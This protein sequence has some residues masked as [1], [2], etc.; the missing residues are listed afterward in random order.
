M[1]CK[2]DCVGSPCIGLMVD[3]LNVCNA[4]NYAKI[5]VPI[6]VGTRTPH[7]CCNWTT[8]WLSLPVFTVWGVSVTKFLCNIYDFGSGMGHAGLAFNVQHH[9]H[10]MIW[11]Q[12]CCSCSDVQHL[13][14]WWLAYDEGMIC[15]GIR[16]GLLTLKISAFY[17]FPSAGSSLLLLPVSLATAWRFLPNECCLVCKAQQGILEFKCKI[18]CNIDII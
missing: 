17:L 7:P 1:F 11:E 9:R 3:L 8:A 6:L 14:I 2:D 4:R 16:I 12:N 18:Q 13:Y 15:Y 5:L 10:C